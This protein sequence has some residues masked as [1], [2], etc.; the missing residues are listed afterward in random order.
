MAVRNLLIEMELPTE[1]I[2]VAVVEGK[3]NANASL[4]KVRSR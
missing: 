3:N 4:V 1:S 2:D